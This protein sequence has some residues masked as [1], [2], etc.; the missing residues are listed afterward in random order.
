MNAWG[1]VWV[2]KKRRGLRGWVLLSLGRSPK[3]GAELMDEM[4]RMS[5]GWWR[6]SPG[7]IYPLLEELSQEK[8]VQRRDDGRYEVTPGS[9]RDLIWPTSGWAP[10]N[11]EEAVRE[12]DGL[13]S[14]LEDLRSSDPEGF[15]A[16]R[17]RLRT[18]TD[19]LLHLA[20]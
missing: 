10:R 20:E 1:N 15:G 2:S 17:P 12:L 7:S 4:E 14:Y 5:G 3:N 11:A 19:R 13:A 8:L 16:V 9:R 6:P 18:A